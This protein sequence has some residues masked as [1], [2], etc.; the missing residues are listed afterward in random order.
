[1]PI[2]RDGRLEEVYWTYSY[3]PIDDPQ[4][5]N[6]VGGVLVHGHGDHGQRAGRAGGERPKLNAS[7]SLFEQAP[8]FVIIMRG[9]NHMVEFVNREHRRL[10]HSDTWPGKTIRT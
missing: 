3:C 4:A 8:G 5:P 10:F 2:H 1:M 6:E 9:P 7:A